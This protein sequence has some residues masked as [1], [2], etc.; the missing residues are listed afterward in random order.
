MDH[1]CHARGCESAVKPELLMC[2]Y[3]WKQVPKNIQQAVYFHYRP[4]QCDDKN[5]SKE[6]M[7][8]ADAA[9][10]YIAKREGH[11]LR[12]SEL[13]A[14]NHF[15]HGVKVPKVV[16]KKSGEPFDIYVGRGSKFGNPYSHIEGTSALWVVETREDAIRLYEEWLR[17]QPELLAAA[18]QE[19]RGKVI[20]C[21]CKPL[22]CHGDILLKIANEEDLDN[23]SI[24]LVK[25]ATS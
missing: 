5:V 18:K 1:H 10:A 17:A 15:G 4:G 23:P 19:L 12:N 2:L 20:S 24:D 13:E 25:S 22:A 21:Y 11:K 9:I 6:W 3:H 16:N 14:L 8:A 7:Q